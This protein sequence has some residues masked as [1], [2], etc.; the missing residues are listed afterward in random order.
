VLLVKSPRADSGERGDLRPAVSRLAHLSHLIALAEVGQ[1]TQEPH[2]QEPDL[3]IGVKTER[4]VGVVSSDLKEF[5]GVHQCKLIPEPIGNMPQVR[6]KCVADLLECRRAGGL[7][8][9]LLRRG[10]PVG[11]LQP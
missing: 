7:G 11:E 10:E 5:L 4:A 2:A 9:R 8:R 1:F 3:G 6:P